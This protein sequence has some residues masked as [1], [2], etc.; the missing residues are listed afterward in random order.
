ML[1]QQKKPMYQDLNHMTNWQHETLDL[2]GMK[3]Q[4]KYLRENKI[5]Q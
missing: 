3:L 5:K 1:C 4:I 2:K